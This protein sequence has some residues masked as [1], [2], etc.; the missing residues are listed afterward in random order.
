MVLNH[1]GNCGDPKKLTQEWKD[2]IAS[3]AK[4]RNV[5]CKVS[6]LVEFDGPDYG[7]APTDPAYYKPVLDHVWET[8]GDDR[9]IFASNWPVSEKGTSYEALFNVVATFFSSKGGE[10][11]EKFFWKNSQAAYKWTDRK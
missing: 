5:Y 7:K 9:L 8:F 10:A 2:G 4:R 3:L 6:A 1:E 11:C